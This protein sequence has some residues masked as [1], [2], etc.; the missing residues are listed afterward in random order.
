MPA[1]HLPGK[2]KREARGNDRETAAEAGEVAVRCQ[3][4]GVHGSIEIAT[5]K[6]PSGA[7]SVALVEERRA[8][9]RHRLRVAHNPPPIDGESEPDASESRPLDRIRFPTRVDQGR[10]EGRTR[11]EAQTSKKGGPEHEKD[12]AAR[13]H[14]VSHTGVRTGRTAAASMNRTRTRGHEHGAKETRV[15]HPPRLRLCLGEGFDPRGCRRVCGEATRAHGW[16]EGR[17]GHRAGG[18]RRRRV[19]GARAAGGLHAISHRRPTM[20]LNNRVF[21]VTNPTLASAPRPAQRGGRPN[22]ETEEE[23]NTQ[24]Y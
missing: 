17:T 16:V 15:G 7:S 24:E 11:P 21:K 9:S 14:S 20:Q 22:P 13:A 2:S 18:V 6:G 19:P 4:E 8:G 23:G 5:K 10:R 3:R 1:Y 12:Y